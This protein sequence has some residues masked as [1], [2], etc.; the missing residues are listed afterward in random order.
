MYN[1]MK[2]ILIGL[3]LF[4]FLNSNKCSEE[5]SQLPIIDS[6][7]TEK[8]VINSEQQRIDSLR[9]IKEKEYL[10]RQEQIVQEKVKTEIILKEKNL[11]KETLLGFLPEKIDGFVG[12]P[13]MTGKTQ[14]DDTSFTVFVKKQF[15]E[16]SGR[17][18]VMFDLFDYGRG[19]KIPN[20]IIY[21][22]VPGD[23]DAPATSYSNKYAGGFSYWLDQKA[24]G[25]LEVLV[26]KR[27]VLIIRLNG[28]NR[29]DKL[30]DKFINL[31]KL[32][33]LYNSAKK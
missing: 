30:F 20:E 24:Y 16:V 26:N 6:V 25:H 5:K 3:F 14:D 27:F 2:A 7:K 9:S 33:S 8:P 19:N 17:K 29:D 22:I 31:V 11:S 21:E 28:F 4:T 12:L 13:H 23:L 1:L 10:A 18:S 15:K 32:N